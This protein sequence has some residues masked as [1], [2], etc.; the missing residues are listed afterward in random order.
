MGVVLSPQNH[1]CHD[2]GH[3]GITPA[4]LWG[5][6]ESPKGTPGLQEVRGLLCLIF[7]GR[8]WGAESLKG[9]VWDPQA[10]P[11]QG[12]QGCDVQGWGRTFHL[13]LPLQHPA[14]PG[15]PGHQ[16]LCPRYFCPPPHVGPRLGRRTC[17]WKALCRSRPAGRG[18]PP[19]DTARCCK[20]RTLL[21]ARLP[22][23]PA[24]CVGSGPALRV[25]MTVSGAVAAPQ[26][27]KALGCS[28]RGGEQK[29]CR[30]ALWPS[31]AGL[32]T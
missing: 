3:E 6:Q 30:T 26:Q 16:G 14:F 1:G 10:S 20:T 21:T 11:G 25:E 24:I 29:G 8:C 22:T 17:C 19:P 5:P 12:R 7:L 23:R 18:R 13:L 32:V 2:C 31:L 9:L 4:D 27:L 15:P 28:P